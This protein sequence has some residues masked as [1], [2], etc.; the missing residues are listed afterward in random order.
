[1]ADLLDTYTPRSISDYTKNSI[2]GDG[3]FDKMMQAAECHIQDEYKHNR[4]TGANYAQ[5][6]MQIMNTVIQTAAQFT[7][8]QDQTWL[9][10]EK[11]KFERE[12]LKYEIEKL[13]AEVELSKAQVDLAKAQLEVEKAKLPYIKA[14]T[15]VEQSKVMDI[16]ESG[17]PVYEGDKTNIHGIGRSE[18]DAHVKAID[19]ATKNEAITLAKELTV[20][21]FSIIESSEGIGSSYY[22]LNGGNTVSYL[23]EVRK[24]F[25]MKEINTTSS[26]AGE[27]AKYKDYW[28]P[29]KSIADDDDDDSKSSES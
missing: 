5:T 14:Q 7:L 12:K 25:G 28:A 18:L 9:E 13:K 6:Y 11:L 24:A 3:V 26:Y 29:G 2:N 19:S 22:G 17:E 1:M 8:S 20:N 16:I 10:L 27:H 4:I 23:N 21:P 15:L